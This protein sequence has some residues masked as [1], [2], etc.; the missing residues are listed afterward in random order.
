MDLQNPNFWATV[1]AEQDDQPRTPTEPRPAARPP[2]PAVRARA[3]TVLPRGWEMEVLA[4]AA[5]RLRRLRSAVNGMRRTLAFLDRFSPRISSR[6]YHAADGHLTAAQVL[7]DGLDGVLAEIA[8]SINGRGSAPEQSQLERHLDQVVG[9]LARL[10]ASASSPASQE[11]PARPA[12][13]QRA[14]RR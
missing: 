9:Q 3:P 8:K 12:Q 6:A 5:T 4:K 13:P 2:A 1:V 11:Q 14:T 10:R 7:F